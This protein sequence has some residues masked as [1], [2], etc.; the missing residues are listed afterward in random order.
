MGASGRAPLGRGEIAACGSDRGKSERDDERSCALNGL[1]R[2]PELGG[3]GLVR[4]GDV[5]ARSAVCCGRIC[6]RHAHERVRRDAY[7]SSS[8]VAGWCGQRT[9]EGG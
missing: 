5:A 1:R 6:A 3:N 2:H 8:L 7:L 9:G 4:S